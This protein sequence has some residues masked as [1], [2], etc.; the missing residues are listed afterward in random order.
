MAFSSYGK[1][2]YDN[3]QIINLSP[4]SVAKLNG[5]IVAGIPTLAFLSHPASIIADTISLFPT[6]QKTAVRKRNY[7]LDNSECAI[8][9]KQNRL[10]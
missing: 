5:V 8:T 6:K 9:F 10:E 2:D 4:N 3:R 1:Q 7:C